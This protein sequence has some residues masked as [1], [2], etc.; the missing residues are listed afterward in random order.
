LIS[1]LPKQ[2]HVNGI[3]KSEIIILEGEASQS[4]NL[5]VVNHV[6]QSVIYPNVFED[7]DLEY[8]I[9]GNQI[10][11]NIILNEYIKDFSVQLTIDI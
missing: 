8:I 2:I 5:R 4:N 6:N 10:K 9:K 11:E 3:N 1:L 7:V